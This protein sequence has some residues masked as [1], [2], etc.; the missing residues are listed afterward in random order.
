[1]KKNMYQQPSVVVT[2]IMMVNTLCASGTGG[3]KFGSGPDYDK[4]T[5]EQ[6]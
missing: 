4:T 1:M 2:D 5:T 6:L 3:T